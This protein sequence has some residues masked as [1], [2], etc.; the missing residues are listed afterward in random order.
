MC[1]VSSRNYVSQLIESLAL[2]PRGWGC[3]L[4][5]RLG[6]S[7]VDESPALALPL[8]LP[9]RGRDHGHIIVVGPEVALP[10]AHRSRSPSDGDDGEVVVVQLAETAR[11]EF[12]SGLARP[13]RALRP[14][15][16]LHLARRRRSSTPTS[17]AVSHFAYDGLNGS[18]SSANFDLSAA[19][20]HFRWIEKRVE[21]P[22]K[23][24]PVVKSSI[25][26]RRRGRGLAV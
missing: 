19:P 4:A 23:D 11:R 2:R 22:E 17:E 15:D 13:P 5:V 12:V 25:L 9:A 1:I 21:A 26:R 24:T 16:A 7:F 20:S 18:V 10:A 3:A 14:Q 8:H 6:R